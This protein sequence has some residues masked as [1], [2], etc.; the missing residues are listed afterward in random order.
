MA[1]SKIIKN[2]DKAYGYNYTSLASIVEAGFDLPQMRVKPTEFGE[3]IEYKDDKGE[4]QIGARIVVPKMNGKNEAQAYGAG[5]TYARRYT[6][7]MAHGIACDD[8]KQV[9]SKA[10]EVKTSQRDVS[11]EID[12]CDS[13]DD[14][15]R[16]YRTLDGKEKVLFKKNF[17]AR[18]EAIEYIDQ[19]KN[20]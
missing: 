3:F 8:D 4:W 6:T 13:V 7:L 9:E 16:L 12:D 14:L 18:K 20:S 2:K 10:P 19:I 17:T 15:N 11:K 1:T 5:L